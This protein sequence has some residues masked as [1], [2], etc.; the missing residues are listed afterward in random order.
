[1]GAL[2]PRAVRNFIDRPRKDFRSYHKISNQQI[3]QLMQQLPARPPIWKNLSRA[4]KI[5]VLIGARTGRF[6]FFADCGVGKTLTA[7]ALARYFAALGSVQKVLVLV[8]RRP[9][10]EEWLDE[11]AKHSPDTAAVVLPPEIEGKWRTLEQ[12]NALLV[13][14]TYL[15]FLRMVTKMET[16]KRGKKKNRLQ[17]NRGLLSRLAKSVQGLVLDESIHAKNKKKLP[18]RICRKISQTSAAVFGLTATPF[19]RD[20]ADL[21]GQ[22]Y[23]VDGG[24]SLGETL[25]LFRKAFYKETPNFWGGVDH[26][27]NPKKERLLHRC[28]A[29]RSIR[30]EADAA[31]LPALVPIVKKVS[32]PVDAELYYQRAKQSLMK[33]GNFKEM[34]NAFVRMRQISSGFVGFWDDDAGKRAEFRFDDNPKLD[35]LLSVIESIDPKHKVIVFHEFIYSGD[36]IGAALKEIKL[37]FARMYSGTKDVRRE[38]DRFNR[39]PK[40]ALLLLQNSFGEGLNL[41]LAKY[42]LYYESP[43]SPIMRYQTR[44][45]FERQHSAHETVFQYDFIVKDTVDERI[46]ESLKAGEDLFDSVINGRSKL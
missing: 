30:F 13:I 38:R 6:L 15:G 1:M 39:D 34:K 26:E 4:Q 42:G 10:K 20:P 45:R 33:A 17:P 44:R 24:Y 41:Q 27:F 14:D 32:L 19:G 36:M 2:A 25:G 11:V 43:V 7:I 18:Y 40:C 8:P 46:Q 9:N 23:L 5:M 22:F 35:Q 3:E 21:W 28:I 37:P 16:A 31:E 12:S 29:H